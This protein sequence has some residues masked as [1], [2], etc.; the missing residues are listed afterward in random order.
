[1]FKKEFSYK[2]I[3][4]LNKLNNSSNYHESYNSYI[5]MKWP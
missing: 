5:A 4:L 3:A 1:M 2:S